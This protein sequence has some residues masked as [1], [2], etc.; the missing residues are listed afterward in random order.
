MLQSCDILYSGLDFSSTSVH[1]EFIP[2]IAFSIRQPSKIRLGKSTPSFLPWTLVPFPLSIASTTPSASLK[3]LNVVPSPVRTTFVWVIFP[4]LYH[5]QCRCLL[6]THFPVKSP[7]NAVLLASIEGEVSQ[8]DRKVTRN[9]PR[10][11]IHRLADAS[12]E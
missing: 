2:G 9:F 8:C 5:K 10:L 3:Q 1:S 4:N 12:S 11:Y 6:P 7:P